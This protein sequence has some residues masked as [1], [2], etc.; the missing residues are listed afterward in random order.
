MIIIAKVM[1]N[2]G[3]FLYLVTLTLTLDQFVTKLWSA[4]LSR[5]PIVCKNFGMIS[6]VLWTLQRAQK[7]Q[8]DRQTD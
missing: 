7:G 4:D 3:L 1:T 6:S 5:I 8:T 2:N